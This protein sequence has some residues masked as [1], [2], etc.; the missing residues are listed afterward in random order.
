[1]AALLTGRSE[2]ELKNAFAI[3]R[4]EIPH[5]AVRLEQLSQRIAQELLGLPASR[6]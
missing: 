2:A 3:L 5:L 6:R 4:M 1:V